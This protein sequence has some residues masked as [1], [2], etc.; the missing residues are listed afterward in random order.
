M[1]ISYTKLVLPIKQLRFL[2]SPNITNKNPWRP[3]KN[4]FIQLKNTILENDMKQV[5]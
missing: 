5:V 3:L 4:I 1:T 2:K